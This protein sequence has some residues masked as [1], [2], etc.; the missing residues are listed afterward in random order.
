MAKTMRQAIAAALCAGCLGTVAWSSTAPDDDTQAV[1]RDARRAAHMD[2]HYADVLVIH[3]AVI[4]G[5]L[6]A[7]RAPARAIAGAATP[8]GLPDATTTY[9]L[10]MRS[11]AR[12]LT[13]AHDVPAAAAVTATMVATCGLCHEA[14]G[15]RPAAAS[16]EPPCVGGTVG[17]MLEHQRALD[18]LLQGLALP[19]TSMWQ[20]GVRGLEQAPLHRS[21]LPA[22]SKLT[23]SIRAAEAHVH[24]LALEARDASSTSSRA[25]VY[26]RLLATCADCHSIH[27]KLWGP[28]P[29]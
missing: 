15:T 6:A 18:H 4:R 24:R 1:P 26:G 27:R 20:E 14:V 2:H 28:G 13:L 3:K 22:D 16:L 11:A 7:V 17:H 9:M 12:R 21:D 19:S 5:D 8:T 23:A 25:T 29:P 10:R